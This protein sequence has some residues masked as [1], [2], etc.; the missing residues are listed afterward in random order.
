MSLTANRPV[1][2]GRETKRH[3]ERINSR[4]TDK[5]SE[6]DKLRARKIE[7]LWTLVILLWQLRCSAF[8]K[9]LLKPRYCVILHIIACLDVCA[10]ERQ[11][12]KTKK[13]GQVCG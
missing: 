12:G 1:R 13:A 6:T 3:M 11:R 9:I 5:E 8:K 10:R 2:T 4:K 7:R